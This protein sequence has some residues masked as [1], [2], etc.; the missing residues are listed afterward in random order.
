MSDKDDNAN[1]P[2]KCGFTA[3]V[4]DP[5]VEGRNEVFITGREDE[6]RQ[7]VDGEAGYGL[8]FDRDGED[9]EMK[10]SM[11]VWSF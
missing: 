8:V 6:E 9:F 4:F 7:P 5:S 10:C 3:D 1:G 11:T 2:V